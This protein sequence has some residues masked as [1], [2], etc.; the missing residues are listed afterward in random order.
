MAWVAFAL[1]LLGI[2]TVGGLRTYLHYRETGDTGHRLRPTF[3]T[4]EWWA[5][6]LMAAALLL[7]ALAP[8][9]AATHVTRPIALF[10]HP[11]IA[12]AGLVLALAGFAGVL[13]AQQAMGA[14]WRVGVD[15]TERTE[16]VTD[17]PFARVRNPIFSAMITATV[18]LT[19][20]VPS[21]PQLLG[22]ACLIAGIQ[23][24]VRAVEEPYLTRTQGSA[25][26]AYTHRAG[27]FLPRIGRRHPH[28]TT[29]A[30]TT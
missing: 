7:G 8:L 5:W 22:L 2:A 18:G 24:Q 6:L 9:L 21:W 10:D 1:Y 13:T 25:Y 3:G 20:M 4:V 16:L 14:S 11:A 27:R 19:A 30:H 15:P 23:I 17:G 28:A 29:Q 26:T 12:V